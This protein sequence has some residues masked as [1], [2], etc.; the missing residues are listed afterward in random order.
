M[1]RHIH[2]IQIRIHGKFHGTFFQCKL[3]FIR[4][5]KAHSL[6]VDSYGKAHSYIHINMIIWEGA[7]I[8]CKFESAYVK[9]HS[10]RAN[11]IPIWM[12]NRIPMWIIH[13]TYDC[14]MSR[15]YEN[16]SFKVWCEVTYDYGMSHVNKARHIWMGHVAYERGTSNKIESFDVW[17]SH[18]TYDYV[19]SHMTMSCHIWMRH[20]TYEWVM[21]HVNESRHSW[22]SPV[23]FERVKSGKIKGGEDP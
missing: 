1:G 16:E 12:S 7:F 18:V 14:V 20:V 5:S 8:E 17:M 15:M 23:T 4:N 6:S 9:T 2:W 10:L 19:M 22:M 13:V 21:Y 3:E 11:S